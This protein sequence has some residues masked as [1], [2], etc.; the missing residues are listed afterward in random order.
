MT[1]SKDANVDLKSRYRTALT[2]SAK[3]PDASNE[4]FAGPD[5]ISLTNAYIN[6]GFKVAFIGKEQ[7]DWAYSYHDFITQPAFNDL[8]H[9]IIEYEKFDFAKAYYKSPYWQF[10]DAI[11]AIAHGTEAPR[12]TLLWTNLIKFVY[13][14]YVKDNSAEKRTRSIVHVAG[15]EPFLELS[16]A[17]FHAEMTA[18][19]PDACIFTTGP[20]LDVVLQRYYPGVVFVPLDLPVRAMARLEHPDLP[21]HSYRVYHPNY[22]S[23]DR[24]GRWD[25]VLAILAREMAQR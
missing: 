13:R 1:Y 20:H 9:A 11:N 4:L 6:S 23:R 19:K 24:K 5:L 7:N 12:Q 22:L 3:T 15:S 21:K 14:Q 18:S 10:F 16:R 25:R 17:L 8:D 2:N